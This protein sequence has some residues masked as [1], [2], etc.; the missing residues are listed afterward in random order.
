MNE[1]DMAAGSGS[2]PYDEPTGEIDLGEATPQRRRRAP[3]EDRDDFYARHAIPPRAAM[4]RVDDL[5]DI[6]PDDI[7]TRA[8]PTD[9]GVPATRSAPVANPAATPDA[10]LPPTPEPAP[11]LETS[12]SEAPTH[13]FASPAAGRTPVPTEHLRTDPGPDETDADDI[14]TATARTDAV[15]AVPAAGLGEGAV[16]T[17]ATERY[18]A[19]V[20]DTAGFDTAAYDTSGYDTDTPANASDDRIRSAEEDLSDAERR[21]RRGTLDLGLLLL[22][23]AVGAIAMAH[24]AQKLFG[25]WNGPRLS[26]FEDMLVNAPNPAIGFQAD[27]AR[28]LAIV[29]A[30]SETLGGLMLVVGLFTPVAAS[31]VLGVML[32]A[33]AYKA[34]LAGGVWFF[35]SG[36]NGAGIEYEALLAVCAAAIILAGPGRIALDAPRGWA[37]RPAWGSLALLVVGIGAAVAVWLVFNGTN[38]FQSPGNPTG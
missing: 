13:R 2:S 32:V 35:A 17:A 15:T 8:I 33:G 29:G 19:G 31:A 38:P 27:A 5:D 24:G 26:G 3:T 20:Y 7:E 25:W 12:S 34:T 1:R 37:R 21:A 14:R 28:P 30:L 9:S 22:R 18:D 10:A 11:P 4:S 16:P 36:G 23:C 6:D